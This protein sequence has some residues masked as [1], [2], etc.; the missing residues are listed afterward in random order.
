MPD[1]K[2]NIIKGA[3]LV[4]CGLLIAFVPNL[5]SFLFY[6]LGA[7]IIFLCAVKLIKAIGN[8]TFDVMFVG[9]IIGALCGLTVMA[10]PHFIKVQ[11]PLIA[12][13]IFAVTGGSRLFKTLSYAQGSDK[14]KGIISA[15]ILIIA[16]IIFI[17]DPL[18]ISSAFRIIIGLI[19]AA[20]GVLN[21]IAAYR[22]KQ[23]NDNIQPDVVNID[24]YTVSDDE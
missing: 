1:N 8:G 19:I 18:K 16:G 4:I 21:L 5:I 22:T 9:C 11:I 20:L 15:A 10:L 6:A 2:S 24:S 17:A 7:V 12:G 13:I 14:K 3:G 23:Q